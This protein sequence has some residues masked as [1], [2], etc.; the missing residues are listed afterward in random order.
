MGYFIRFRGILS[1]FNQLL[2]PKIMKRFLLISLF[3]ISCLTISAQENTALT[4]ADGIDN[5][6]DG[7]IDCMDGD[8]INLPNEGCAT[9]S[10]GITFADTVI[11]YL[12]GCPDNISPI[13]ESTLGVSDYVLGNDD[14]YLYLGEG[15]SIKLGFT[16]NTLTN[17]GDSSNDVFVFEIGELV[18][19]CTLAFRP[20]DDFTA[21]Q[22]QNAGIPDVNGDGFYEFGDVG[23][24]T[25]GF[26]IDS[27]LTGYNSGQLI[28]DAIEITDVVDLAC[29]NSTP[30][31]DIDAVCALSFEQVSINANNLGSLKVF[32][33]PTKGDFT[34]ELE[35]EYKD[36][37][38]RITNVMGQIISMEKY[39]SAKTIFQN[40]NA[41]EGTYFIKVS[42]A[43]EGSSTL[44]IIKQ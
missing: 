37:T 5:D 22:L 10:E 36:V 28:F 40:I 13:P 7:L 8:C 6:G 15:G 4:C 25:A 39:T 18:E 34:I 27:V 9:C 1:I 44:R 42:T 14:T 29:T 2:K 24:A 20:A 32:P 38:V 43:N 35:R 33:N 16:N 11:E 21:M 30:G 3:S 26:D 31:A 41:S 19:D 23:G 17:S 12:P